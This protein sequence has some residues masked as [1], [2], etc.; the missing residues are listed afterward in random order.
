MRQRGKQ[1]LTPPFI[2]HLSGSSLPFFTL[3]TSSSQEE[4]PWVRHHCGTQ[5]ITQT[6]T[7]RPCPWN[8]HMPGGKA[9]RAAPFP[10]STQPGR[11]G[12]TGSGMWGPETVPASASLSWCV[13]SEALRVP[14]AKQ[15]PGH[16]AL[17]TRHI[18]VTS[19][20][21]WNHQCSPLKWFQRRWTVFNISKI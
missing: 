7:S 13:S 6:P 4:K 18:Q 20:L 1:R 10:L 19:C 5:S 12:G 9:L 2:F 3:T 16:L 21:L 15:N 17:P 11:E 8:G 14:S